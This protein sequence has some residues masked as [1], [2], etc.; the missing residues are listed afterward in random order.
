MRKKPEP[1]IRR[2]EAADPFLD[3][4]GL[5]RP[6]ATRWRKIVA[7]GRWAIAFPK[8]DDLLFCSVVEGECLLV[9]PA[10]EPLK[11]HQG[12]FILI[13]TDT[14]FCFASDARVPAES[15]EKAFAASRTGVIRLGGGRKRPVLLR[16]GRFVLDTANES[17]LT[18]L[19]P[20]LIHVRGESGRSER[21]QNLLHMNASESAACEP[22]SDFVIPRL[23]EILFVE[24]L[25]DESRRV[26]STN[27]GLLA[28]LEHPVTAKALRLMHAEP[29]RGWTVET[30]ARRSGASRSRFALQFQN[31]LGTSPMHYLLHWRIALAKNSLRNGTRSISEIAFDVGFHSVSA[32]STA[33]RRNVGQ[34][35]K[36]FADTSSREG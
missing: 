23:M 15:S 24:L 26:D 21:I 34:S 28:G 8:R 25:R 30:L 12:D 1:F 2:P 16:G 29:A 4:I 33:F 17:L 9:R 36:Q 13:R 5:L 14:P 7:A 3:L 22:G 32:F 27:T 35:P 11:L 6:K 31:T 18:Q 19:M 20:S 10:T